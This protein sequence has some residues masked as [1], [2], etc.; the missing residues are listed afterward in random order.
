M[1]QYAPSHNAVFSGSHAYSW[2]FSAR[3]KI[4]GGLAVVGDT[5]YADTFAGT[6][7][8]L[9]RRNGHLLWRAHLSNVV[10]T[11]PIVAD[12]V[13]IVGTGRDHTLFE[14]GRR[15]VWGVSGGD[16]V[17]AFDTG[18]GRLRWSYRTVGEDMPGAALVSVGGRDAVVFANGDGHAR[19]LDV[20]TGHLLWSA[21]IGGVSTMGSAV[22]A[23]ALVY[24]ISGYAAAMHRPD[25]VFALRAD[26]GARVW[27]APYGNADDSPVLGDGRLF[28]EDAQ[29]INGPSNADAMNDVYAL[30][31]SSG[32]LVW[33]RNAGVGFFTRT[34]TNEQ[35]IA[36]M[37]D[38]G[39]LFQSL[40]A[41]RRF[42]AY[43]GDQGR[44]QWS[45]LTQAAVK[46]S[47]V[48]AG[49]RVYVGDTA[50]VLYTIQEGSGRVLSRR[51]FSKSFTC[52]SPVVVGKTLYIADDDAIYALRLP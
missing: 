38:R 10:M 46:M 23:G 31:L 50:G 35:A 27:S 37:F 19:A 28:I 6:L 13:A 45:M 48:A 7:V 1:Y 4:N 8:A 32:H 51:H 5:L 44:V 39:A 29:R 30:D 20:R 2:R 9:N 40:P 52:S 14:D 3:A 43:A 47:A 22:T 15:L 25:H 41:A 33:S 34:G 26:D 24:V 36:A 49:G 42:T 18:T 12:G 21:A 11:T 16:E 17:A